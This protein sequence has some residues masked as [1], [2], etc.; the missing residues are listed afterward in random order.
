M[1]VLK[2]AFRRLAKG[3]RYPAFFMARFD[4][5]KIIRGIMPSGTKGF[6]LRKALIT[7]QFVIAILLMIC[8]LSIDK[9]ISFMKDQ[10]NFGFETKKRLVLR[11][12]TTKFDSAR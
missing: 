8:A 6:V 4:P 11:V 10:E 2:Y 3:W 12:G 1:L 9:Q 5:E 7:L